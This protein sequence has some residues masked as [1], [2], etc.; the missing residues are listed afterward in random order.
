MY[1]GAIGS[2]GPRY[3]PSVEDKVVKFPDAERHQIFLEPEGL[4]T[5]ELY[6][7]GLSTSLP[8]DVQLAVLRTIP[9]L[10]DAR[11]TRAGYAIEYDF[12]PP[13]Q[14]DPSF[15]VKALRGLYFAGQINGTTGYEEAAGQGVLA[16]IN[17]GLAALGRPPI[18]LGRHTSYIGVLADDLVTRGVDEPYRLFTSRSEFRLTIRQDNALRRLAPVGLELGLYTEPEAAAIARA[19]D[20]EEQLMSVAR[21]T[22][23]RPEAVA[24]ILDG[25]G[26]A[27]LPH[28]MRIADVVK[29]QGVSF[30]RL[31]EAAGVSGDGWGDAI[32]TTELELKYEGYFERERTQAEKMRRMGDF[33]LDESLPY[34]EMRS[35]STEAR[36]KL[37]AIRPR[38]LAQAS[39]ISG[40][41]QS[42]LQ[43]L[44]IEVERWRRVAARKPT[45][46]S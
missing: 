26:S 2:K 15:Q 13:T 8:A 11:M 1:G 41:S 30:A 14:L 39:R 34:G 3:C 31:L 21:S 33:A 43:N 19:F 20:A 18:Y 27:P 44:V 28:P 35:L 29:R 32:V 17:A 38:T 25:A 45:A 24:E 7:N 6:V 23:V 46:S 37:T 42:D 5:S 12:F 40:V 22:S 9:G 36:Q 4:D 16:G 10:A